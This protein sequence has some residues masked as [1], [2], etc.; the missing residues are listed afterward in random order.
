M[1]ISR[2][3]I[4]VATHD[5]AN[6][7][8]RV[9]VNYIAYQRPYRRPAATGRRIWPSPPTTRRRKNFGCSVSTISPPWWPIRAICWARVR[10]IGAD[11][12]R[13]ADGDRQLRKG[14]SHPGRQAHRD[15]SEQSGASPTSASNVTGPNDEQTP[16]MPRVSAPRR[17][18]GRCR[19]SPSTPSANFPTPAPPCSAPAPTAACPRRICTVQLGGIDAAVE[20]SITARSRPIC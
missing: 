15:R 2:D 8:P 12:A 9:E 20:H 16:T 11:A 7:D 1:G 19:A 6:G 17:M 3:Q 18:S 13:R 5:A 10:W 4:L 14:R